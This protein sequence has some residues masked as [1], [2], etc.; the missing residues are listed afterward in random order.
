[1][2]EP[3]VWNEESLKALIRDAVNESLTLDYKAAGALTL[4]TDGVK[5]E[6][7]KDVS[8]FANSAGGTIVYGVSEANHVPAAIDGID[9]VQVTREW[10]DQVIASR[11]QRRI[12]NVRIHQIVLSNGK[13]VYVVVIPQSERA[14]H[15]AS[16][17]RY[18]KRF[19]FHSVAMEEYEVRD[20]ANRAVGPRL[21]VKMW[22]DTATLSFDADD[23]SQPVTI[24]AQL[25]NDSPSPA[26]YAV[27]HF[28]ADA[29]LR[30]QPGGF[31]NRN[32]I[33]LSVGTAPATPHHL[34]QLN[35]SVPGKL[36]IW[37]GMNFNFFDP[38]Y[39]VRIPR[40]VATYVLGWSAKAPRMTNAG[41]TYLLNATGDGA[42]EL[43]PGP[44]LSL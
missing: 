14:P 37:N 1:M 10:L 24:R 5:N 40:G 9:P 3:T 13:V 22:T 31:M 2:I 28:V 18:Y 32:E 36:P 34:W 25:L 43:R 30:G 27:L 39:E 17:H 11:I 35:W 23:Y 42:V 21:G 44:S 16:D 29:R 7:S 6:I 15:M 33:S 20:I 12:D 26:D 4:K 8:A 38:S 41:E 19:E